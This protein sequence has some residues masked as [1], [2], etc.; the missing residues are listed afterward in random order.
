MIVRAA[1]VRSLVAAGFVPALG[2][3]HHSQLNAFNLA[4]D[5]MEPFRPVVD[6]RAVEVAGTDEKLSSAQRKSLRG[7]L[8]D[9]VRL[10]SGGTS[11][12]R[13]IESMGTGLRGAIYCEDAGLL[14]LPELAGSVSVG[15]EAACA[16]AGEQC[17]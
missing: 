8:Y 12:L 5:L 1:M 13:A 6:L 7:V 3:H 17:A 2:I 9:E 11:V 16:T 14:P 10:G 15:P 4:D